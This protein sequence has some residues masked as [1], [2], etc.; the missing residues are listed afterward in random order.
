MPRGPR[1]APVSWSPLCIS[2]ERYKEAIVGAIDSGTVILGGDR[3]PTRV[4]RNCVA[5]RLKDEGLHE[6]LQGAKIDSSAW[7]A[8]F[9]A[10]KARAAMMGGDLESGIVYTGVGSGLI[11]E[12][13]TVH[14][15][16]EELEQWTQTLAM[17]LA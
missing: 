10:A 13:L 17:T 9:G 11:S 3:W 1:W 16:L 4:L 2:G 5:L 7:E 8:K 12:I 14:R 15:A 6:G